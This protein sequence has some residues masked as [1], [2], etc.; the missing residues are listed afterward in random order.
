MPLKATEY[1]KLLGEKITHHDSKVY[2]INTGWSGGP[3]GIGKRIDLK[4]TRLMV[5][6]CY[7]WTFEECMI[8]ITHNI[9]NLDYPTSCPEMYLQ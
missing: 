1:A 8:M 9:F 6:C 3:Y 7:K 2:L 5:S 4:Y